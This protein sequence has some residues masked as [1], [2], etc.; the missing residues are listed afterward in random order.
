MTGAQSYADRLLRSR[1][2]AFASGCLPPGVTLRIRERHKGIEAFFL[3][4][5]GLD[6]R[7]IPECTRLARSKSESRPERFCFEG[8]DAEL[9]DYLDYH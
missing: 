6:K 8:K 4:I 5:S 9:V 7:K 3:R 2:P 1:T